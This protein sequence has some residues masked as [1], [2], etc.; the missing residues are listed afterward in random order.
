M[1]EGVTRT[2]SKYLKTY[3]HDFPLEQMLNKTFDDKADCFSVFLAF[4]K[5]HLA[6]FFTQLW[7]EFSA[8]Q[9]LVMGPFSGYLS[10][11]LI[12]VLLMLRSC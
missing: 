6:D 11:W 9:F 5:I 3:L 1:V 4:C 8:F 12:K 2:S 7:I 10:V